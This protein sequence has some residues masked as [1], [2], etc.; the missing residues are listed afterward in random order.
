MIVFY[1]QNLQ[2]GVPLELGK[3]ILTEIAK[4]NGI[5]SLFLASQID[6]YENDAN[7]QPVRETMGK[8]LLKQV[9]KVGPKY[10]LLKISFSF[11]WNP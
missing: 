3:E 2:E 5:Q 6:E 4:K 7:L 11:L 1:L 10:G 8:S 9:Q